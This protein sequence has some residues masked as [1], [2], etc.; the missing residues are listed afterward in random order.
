MTKY[1][2]PSTDIMG[3]LFK[4][5]ELVRNLKR[6]SD[7]NA[8]GAKAHD[9]AFKRLWYKKAAQLADETSSNCVSFKRNVEKNQSEIKKLLS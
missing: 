6:V 8:A 1:K 3:D 2:L 7:L 9:P 5:Y 4:G